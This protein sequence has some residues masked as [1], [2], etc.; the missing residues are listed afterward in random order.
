MSCNAR[1]DIFKC[2]KTKS[3]DECFRECAPDLLEVCEIG[4]APFSLRQ[5]AE[6]FKELAGKPNLAV[7]RVIL[8][9]AAGM[10]E[11]LTTEAENREAAIAKAKK[12]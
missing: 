4:V 6:R 1:K 2:Q 8:G 5:Y 7:Y 12:K 9:N 10:F 11:I 3:C